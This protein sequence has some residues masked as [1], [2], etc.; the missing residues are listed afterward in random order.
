[1][2][3]SKYLNPQNDFAFKRIFGQEKNKEI[4]ISMLNAVLKNQLHHDIKDV[5]FL[6]TSQDP[7]IASQK[8]SIVDVLCKDEDGCQYIVEM[9]IARTE[10]FEKRALFYASKAYVDQAEVGE[11]YHNLKEVIFLAF[12]NHIL[13]PKKEHYKSEHVILDKVTLAQDMKYMSFTFVELPKFGKQCPEDISKLSLEEKFYH[14]LYKAPAMSDADLTKLT[15]RDVV[16]KK[17]FD[18]LER[19]SWTEEELNTYDQVQKRERD[20]LSALLY[21]KKEGKKEGLAEGIEKGKQ[22][23][24]AEGIEKGKEEE[25]KAMAAKMRKAGVAPALIDKIIQKYKENK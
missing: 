11:K 9:K 17:A 7:E 3:T 4:L 8:Q 5:I 18:E 16:I 15:G 13:F 1:M 24:L 14:F 19:F 2:I 21:A 25:R 22:E 10:G 12:T 23:G 6:K 20:N